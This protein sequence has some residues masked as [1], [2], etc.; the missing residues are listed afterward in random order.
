MALEFNTN[1]LLDGNIFKYE[2]RLHSHV[3]KFV[4]N[5]RILT[6]YYNLDEDAT[7]VDRGLQDIEQLFGAKSPM[8]YHRIENFPLLALQAINPTNSDETQTEDVVA[9]GECQVEPSTI[10]PHQNDCFVIK[11]LK[12]LAVF[13]V[14]EVTYDSM[15]QDGFYKIAYRLFSTAPDTLKNMERQVT[16]RFICDLNAVGGKLN[17]IIREDNFILREKI[18]KMTSE[19]IESYRA[20]FYNARHNCF[21]IS[22]P[23]IGYR[24]FDLCGNTFIARHSLMNTENGAN[25]I[26]LHEKLS[27]PREELLYNS[28]IYKWIERD[29]PKKFLNE[30]KFNIV[31]GETYIESSFY[32]WRDSD[33][34]VMLP[35]DPICRHIEG[36]PGFSQEQLKIFMDDDVGNNPYDTFLSQYINGRVTSIEDIPLELAD[37]LFSLI[38]DF[39]VFLYT[40]IIIYIIRKVLSF[41]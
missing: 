7:T 2:E 6:T 39:D 20:M 18:K 24:L 40:P 3:N 5:G 15:K 25:V 41:N 8:R 16:S 33:I 35:V 37:G 38:C 4:E 14:T 32:R 23:D 13:Q 21:L 12:M 10:V 22:D 27:E 34:R 9:N 26:M 28:S 11:H 19:M 31:P 17:P 29:A 36:R 30:F 1:V